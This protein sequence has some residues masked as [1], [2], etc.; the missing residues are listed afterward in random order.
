VTR[1]PFVVDVVAL[2]RHD[3]QRERLVTHGR[4]VGMAVTG[5]AVPDDADVSVDVTMEAVAGGIVVRGRVAAPWVGECRRCLR[6]LSGEALAE[7]DEVF[8][9]APEE[10]ETWPIDHNRIDL[11]PMTREAVVLELPLAPL[12]R[13]DCQG[14]CPTCGAE[15]NAG[16]CG[17]SPPAPDPRWAALEALRPAPP[18]EG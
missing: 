18:A 3:G 10:G 8:V 17:C 9:P 14:L 7:V 11:Q 2:R 5:S 15:L 12:C 16:P 4:L 1:T 6:S 13:P